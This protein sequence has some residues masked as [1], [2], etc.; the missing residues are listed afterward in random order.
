MAQQR[1]SAAWR[2]IE[3]IQLERIRRLHE[4]VQS[5]AANS[6]FDRRHLMTEE[7]QRAADGVGRLLG[8]GD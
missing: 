3:G 5:F 8:G 1:P 4:L 2:E 7:E 6:S